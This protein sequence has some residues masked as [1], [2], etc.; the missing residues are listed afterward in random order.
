[1]ELLNEKLIKLAKRLEVI[2]EIYLNAEEGSEDED[3]LSLSLSYFEDVINDIEE[4]IQDVEWEF[5]IN[6]R[7][8][9]K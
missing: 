6:D 1:M 9:R 2:E 3:S 5:N 8:T 7:R 4:K